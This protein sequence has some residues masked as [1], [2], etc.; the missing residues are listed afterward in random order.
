VSDPRRAD[1]VSLVVLVPVLD[2]WPAVSALVARLG[3]MAQG[4][5]LATALLVVDDGSTESSDGVR[6]AAEGL[7][8]VRVLRL[9]RNLG[10]Q[11]AIAV[12]LCY[13][14]EHIAC[15][16]VVVMDG[17]GED[18]PE[19]VPALVMKSASDAH[20]PVVFAERQR[21]VEGALFRLGYAAYRLLHRVLTGSDVRFGNFSAVPR[22]RLESLTVVS[23]LW[24]HYAAS[25]LR[26]KQ[27]WCTIPLQRAQRLNGTSRMNFVALVVHGLSA[28]SVY[29]DVVF[30][31]L[32]VAT[33]ALSA[34]ALAGLATVT[35]VRLGTNLAIPG[36]ATSTV[37][38]LL[39]VL[40]QA[41]SFVSSLVF[42]VLGARQQA[43]VIPRRDYA[44]YVSNVVEPPSTAASE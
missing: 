25:V 39:L 30:T 43:V 37:G 19:D 29:S 23:E 14:D 18:R 42:L 4:L 34:L 7:A 32:V 10:H 22:Q 27:P 1:A 12:G 13:I 40:I 3:A 17:D 11:R 44:Y 38:L 20:A 8:W 2:D 21:R 35:L 15:E 5:G 28:I 36:W 16:T 31:R 41:V 9:R 33:A 24:I 26:S 6:L